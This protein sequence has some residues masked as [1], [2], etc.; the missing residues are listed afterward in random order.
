YYRQRLA[1]GV[2]ERALFR[3]DVRPAPC[4]ISRKNAVRARIYRLRGYDISQIHDI[5]DA[6]VQALRGDRREYVRSLANQRDAARCKT[7][8]L[9]G[10]EGIDLPP[11]LNRYL[12][13]ERLVARLD[14]SRQRLVIQGRKRLSVLRSHDPDKA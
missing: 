7:R 10:G 6:K 4:I 13:E 5:A 1:N 14:A 2:T 9:N 8:G 11:W 12:A 3:S